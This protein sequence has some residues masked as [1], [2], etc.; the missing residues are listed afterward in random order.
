MDAVDAKKA[1]GASIFALLIPSLPY[2]TGKDAWSHCMS[3]K[4]TFMIVEIPNLRM[5][6][7]SVRSG[8]QSN[9]MSEEDILI[10]AC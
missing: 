2:L 10:L 5:L 4:S 1:E 7:N 8:F 6:S 3:L 9:Q